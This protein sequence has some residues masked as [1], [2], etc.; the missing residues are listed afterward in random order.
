MKI[1]WSVVATIASPIIALFV[2][3]VLNRFIERKPRLIAYF[4]HATAFP[5]TGAN[6]GTIHTHGIVI[7]NTGRHPAIDIRVR[8]NF[9]PEHFNIHPGVEYQVQRLSNGGAEIIFPRLVQNEQVSISYLYFPPVV[10]S[11]IHAGIRHS[12]GFATE[13]TALPTPQYPPWILRGLLL[14]LIVG[15]ITIFYIVF[16]GFYFVCAVLRRLTN[17]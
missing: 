3:A 11:Q 6:P 4:T 7:K 13:V 2:G 9:L 8:H 5:L 14:L 10:Y 12:D 15:S 16:E 17:S 1:D